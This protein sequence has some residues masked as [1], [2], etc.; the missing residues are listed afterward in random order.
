MTTPRSVVL[1]HGFAGTTATWDDVRAAWSAPAIALALP[2]HGAAPVA[3][4]WD[5]NLDVVAAQVPA[6]AIAVGYSL[7]ARV[8][9]GLLARDRVAA[10][11]L[12]GVNPGLAS[13]DE[14]AARITSDA[15]WA[16]RLRADGTA[17]FLATWQ[18][19]PLFATQARAPAERRARRQRE[20]ASLDAEAL[21]RSL[22]TMGLGRMPDY[23]AALV[24]RAPRAHL[25]VG[26]DD[27]AYVERARSLVAAA[28]R[29][30][31]DVI[32]ASGHDPT[33]EQ[34]AALAAVLARVIPHLP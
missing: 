26:A 9:L 2:G 27:H 34:P 5:A 8:A 20:R 18:A 33:L 28:P 31:L 30:G 21:A 24:A 13:D 23:R 4:S 25:V 17:A 10:A 15:A 12:I 14:R 7:G 3:A 29:L 32:G 1:L 19:Q 6:G 16:A 22:E 11:V